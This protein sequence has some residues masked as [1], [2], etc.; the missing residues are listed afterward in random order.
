MSTKKV[1]PT[2]RNRRKSARRHAADKAHKKRTKR[3]CAH[4]KHR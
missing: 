1:N 4:A 2:G 3:L